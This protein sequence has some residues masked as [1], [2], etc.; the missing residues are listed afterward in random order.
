METN[1]TQQA[2]RAAHIAVDLDSKYIPSTTMTY[3]IYTM[4]SGRKIAEFTP[5]A[6]PDNCWFGQV[7]MWDAEKGFAQHPVKQGNTWAVPQGYF[8][9]GTTDDDI[10]S[11]VAG[12]SKY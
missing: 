7:R 11:T 3:D 1:N 9:P 4:P 12:F 6:H 10:V 8:P 5:A 2:Q